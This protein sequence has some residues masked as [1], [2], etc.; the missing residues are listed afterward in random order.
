MDN[1]ELGNMAVC[2]Y[3]MYSDLVCGHGAGR[4]HASRSETWKAA[5]QGQCLITALAMKR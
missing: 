3:G 4:L 2:M 5:A 1:K